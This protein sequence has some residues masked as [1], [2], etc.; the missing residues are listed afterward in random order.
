MKEKEES[1]CCGEKQ[2]IRSAEQKKSL[3]NRLKRMEGQVRGIQSMLEKDAYCNDILVQS[4]AVSAAINAFNKEILAYHIHNC[5]VRD[6]RDGKDE[7]ID[8]LVTTVQ[9]LMR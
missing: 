4:A 7:V 8:E 3:M 1:C 5:V 9:K 6:I 2:T